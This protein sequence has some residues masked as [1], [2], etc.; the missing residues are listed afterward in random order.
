MALVPARTE[1]F[2]AAQKVL[3]S[4][5]RSPSVEARNVASAAETSANSYI[6]FRRVLYVSPPLSWK[7]G[8]QL[9]EIHLEIERLVKK[10]QNGLPLEEWP[11]QERLDHLNHLLLCYQSAVSFFWTACKPVSWLKRWRFRKTN[12]FQDCSSQEIGELIGFFSMC[13]M[14]SRVSMVASS[15]NRPSLSLST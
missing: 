2:E 13:R 3:R 1:D 5:I 4:E 6:T 15:A 12:P 11:D 9:Q 8:A 7:I 10:E 14:K